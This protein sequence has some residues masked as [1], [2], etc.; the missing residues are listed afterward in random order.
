MN[1]RLG[2]QSR[3]EVRGEKGPLGGGEP[4]LVWELR[5]RLYEKGIQELSWE[6]AGAEG[7]CSRQ[8][9]HVLWQECDH[10]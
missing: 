2:M 3:S 7:G 4:D 10:S 8:E 9:Q 6:G 1:D 5:G